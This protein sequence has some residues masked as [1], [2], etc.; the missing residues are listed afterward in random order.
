[1]SHALVHCHRLQ[2]KNKNE[3]LILQTMQH[4][5]ASRNEFL[6]ARKA[7]AGEGSG[8]AI[9]RQTFNKLEVVFLTHMCSSDPEVISATADCLGLLCEESDILIEVVQNEDMI[10]FLQPNLEVYRQLSKFGQR[11]FTA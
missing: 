10:E 6:R 11:T 3:V 1:M 8:T 7:L 9:H 4:I 5:M 2:V